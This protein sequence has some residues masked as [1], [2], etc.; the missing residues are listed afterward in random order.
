MTDAATPNQTENNSDA[1]ADGIIV[2]SQK[3]APKARRG[4]P[5]STSVKSD[6]ERQDLRRTRKSAALTQLV[7]RLRDAKKTG[8]WSEVEAVADLLLQF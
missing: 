1:A 8:N 7:F 4:R 6:A 5:V 3:I 2:T